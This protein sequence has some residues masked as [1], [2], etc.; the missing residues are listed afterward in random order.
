[1]SRGDNG[2]WEAVRFSI[3]YLFGNIVLDDAPPN[4]YLIGN[5]EA[6][7]AII[8]IKHRGLR[9]LFIRG[10]TARVGKQHQTNALL[11]MDF[12]HAVADLKDCTGVR[13]FHALKGHRGN[14]DVRYAMSVSGNYRIVFAFDDGDV[15]IDG[16][17]DYH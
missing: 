9:E 1:M 4:H 16:F 10:R 12:L 17:V 5:N 3:I 13:D 11:I 7:M 14:E 6:V 8:K 2:E 15:T